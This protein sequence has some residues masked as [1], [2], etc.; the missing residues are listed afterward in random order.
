M[1]VYLGYDTVTKQ[2]LKSLPGG[3]SSGSSGSPTTSGFTMTGNI[4]MGENEIVGLDNA[5]SGSSATSKKYVDDNFLRS[6]EDIDMRGHEVKG[7][8]VPT[9]DTSATKKKYVDDKVFTASSGGGGLTPTQANSKYLSKTDAASTYETKT[10]A[11]STY[12][13]IGASYTKTDPTANIP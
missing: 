13:P 5:H 2:Y 10:D 3:S 11:A 6:S 8:G 12:A 9:T 1:S 7:L 4:N